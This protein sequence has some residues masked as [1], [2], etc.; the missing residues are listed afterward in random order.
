MIFFFE[1]QIFNVDE[2][3]LVNNLR[4]KKESSAEE[5]KQRM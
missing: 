5:G 1:F 3:V 4:S 2:E